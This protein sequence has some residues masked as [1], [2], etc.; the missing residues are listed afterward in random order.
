M[1]IP[2]CGTSV[3]LQVYLGS[4]VKVAVVLT[5]AMV[6]PQW[7]NYCGKTFRSWVGESISDKGNISVHLGPRLTLSARTGLGVSLIALTV[8]LHQTG[9]SPHCHPAGTTHWSQQGNGLSMGQEPEG[10]EKDLHT[11]TQHQ[12]IMPVKAPKLPIWNGG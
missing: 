7:S 2:P 12:D 8:S 1:I 11:S 5:D 10:K 9:E 4:G 3:S 6:G